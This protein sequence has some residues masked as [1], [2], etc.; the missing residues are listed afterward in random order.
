MR[1]GINPNRNARVGEGKRAVATVI[2]H[3]PYLHGYHQDRL[4]IV[5]FS[6][7]TMRKHAGV[8]CGIAVWDNGSCEELT[9][10]LRLVY[11]P[12]Q[13][14]LSNNIGKW[15][16][17]TALLRMY[18]P[19]TIIGI[20]DDDMLYYPG[21]LAESIQILETYPDVGVVSGYPVRTGFRWGNKNTIAWAM[22]RAQMQVGRFISEQEEK[23]FAASIGRTWEAH[24]QMTATD[25]DYLAEYNGV[26][27]YLTGHHCQFICYASRM[28][29]FLEW[30][31]IAMPDEKPFD[32]AIDAAKLLRLTTAQR[33]T[34]HMG[35]VLD[36]DIRAEVKKLL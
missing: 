33:Y 18:H 13:L 29:P 32:N 4:N 10:W 11:Q 14:I 22:K 15:S 3:I 26:K 6:L 2:T 7:L 25:Q 23:D 28:Q 30:T 36:E 12:D 20:A 27:A 17:R 19:D 35:N 8:D 16:A 1:V 34:R 5:K 9:D 31:D 24:Q 21:W